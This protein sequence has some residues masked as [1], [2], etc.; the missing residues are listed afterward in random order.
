VLVQ[1][2]D[3][4]GI[5]PSE[6]PIFFLEAFQHVAVSTLARRERTPISSSARS[7]ARLVIKGPG[8]AFQPAVFCALARDDEQELIAVVEPA[9][10][11]GHEHA[12]AVPIERN[13]QIGLVLG[14]RPLQ[15]PGCTVPPHR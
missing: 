1:A 7:S 6:L 3:V 11:V 9:L 14:D 10:P 4:P 8:N 15:H 5:L 2:D 13:A 12:I